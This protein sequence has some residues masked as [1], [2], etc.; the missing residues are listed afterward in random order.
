M[1]EVERTNSIFKTKAI[2]Y[3]ERKLTKSIQQ[4]LKE[5]SEACERI[6]ILILPDFVT[7]TSQSLQQAEDNK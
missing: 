5:G 4:V 1:N 6:A 2:A 7:T 3:Q